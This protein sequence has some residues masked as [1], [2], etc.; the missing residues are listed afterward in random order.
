MQFN[1]KILM[2]ETKVEPCGL[3]TCYHRIQTIMKHYHETNVYTVR[4]MG[5]MHHTECNFSRVRAFP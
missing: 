1:I 2:I 4:V 3:V 5:E